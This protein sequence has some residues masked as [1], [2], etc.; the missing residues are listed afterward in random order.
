MPAQGP[1]EAPALEQDCLKAL[2]PDVIL[3]GG[4]AFIF[5]MGGAGIYIF[6]RALALPRAIATTAKPKCHTLRDHKPQNNGPIAVAQGI[7]PST[8]LVH[9]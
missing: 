1:W 5:T 2:L 3:A 4:L 8:V 6:P 9:L 7:V